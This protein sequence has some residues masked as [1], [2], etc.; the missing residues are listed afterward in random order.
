[1]GRFLVSDVLTYQDYLPYRDV[2][3]FWRNYCDPR[4]SGGEVFAPMQMI[5]YGQG[6]AADSFLVFIYVPGHPASEMRGYR[7][8]GWHAARRC[9]WRLYDEAWSRFMLG[10]MQSGV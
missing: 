10:D 9:A 4:C 1:M 6:V 2:V 5:F 3:P 7:T 8:T